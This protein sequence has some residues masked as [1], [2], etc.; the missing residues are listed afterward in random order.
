MSE[1]LPDGINEETRRNRRFQQEFLRAHPP[2]IRFAPS[3]R[4]GASADAGAVDHFEFMMALIE[5]HPIIPLEVCS[6]GSDLL[7]ARR[8]LAYH[9][10][11]RQLGHARSLV[12]NANIKNRVGIGVSL[13]CMLEMYAFAQF[14]SQPDRLNDYRLIEVFLLGQSFASGGWYQWERIWEETHGE[15]MPEAARQL[16]EKLLGLPRLK[17]ILKPAHEQDKGFSYLY[18]RYSE[19]VHPA[20]A[21]PRAEF[22]GELGELKSEDRNSFGSSEYYA[23]EVREGAPTKLI[24]GDISAG[25]FCLEM[26]WPVVL[27]ID[28]HFDDEL[29]PG[30]V[31][32]LEKLGL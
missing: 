24:L 1:S 2:L 26:F 9:I 5:V 21:N 22:E 16:F 12:V 19:Y 30:I 15:P 3:V 20:F 8:A 31:Q 10:M 7:D 14:F 32:I 4:D 6:F 25:G 28:P 13:R 29:R 27:K 23:R 17:T 18:S 11:I